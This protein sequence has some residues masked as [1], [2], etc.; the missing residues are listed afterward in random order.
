MPHTPRTRG[1]AQAPNRPLTCPFDARLEHVPGAARQVRTNRLGHGVVRAGRGRAHRRPIAELELRH[2]L[3]ARA[4]DRI[5]AARATGLRNLP[6]HTTAQNK[7]WLEIVQ[8]ALDLLAWMPM[9]AQHW[10]TR[11]RSH[12]RAGPRGFRALESHHVHQG[13]PLRS[14]EEDTR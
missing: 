5:R 4:E 13:G 11:G 10:H 1:P 2:R 14:E 9:L 6:L 12:L 3:R 7:A 8:I